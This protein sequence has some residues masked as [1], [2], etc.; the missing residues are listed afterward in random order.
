MFNTETGIKTISAEK[1]QHL[2]GGLPDCRLC[3]NAVGNLLI[4]APDDEH[5][6]GYI[7]FNEEEVVL[8]KRIEETPP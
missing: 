8:F 3:V 1:L 4:I 6:L 2:L 7:D 5:R